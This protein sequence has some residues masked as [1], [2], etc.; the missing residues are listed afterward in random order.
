LR[1]PFINLA[2]QYES[3]KTELDEAVGRVLASGM[4]V[5]GEEVERFEEEFARY[6]GASHAVACSSGTSAIKLALLGA[7]IADGDEVITAANSFIATAGAIVHAGARPVFVDVDPATCNMDPGLVERAITPRTRAIVG[8]HLYG[9]PMDMDPVMEIAEAKG[10]VL[11]ED[12]A[13]AHGARYKGAHVGSIGHAGCF[14]FYPTKNLGACGEAGAVVTHSSEM[15]YKLRLLRDHGSESKYVHC[16][17]GYND[18]MDA[19][20]AAALRVKLRH[21]DEWV[22]SRRSLAREYGALLEGL[23]VETPVEMS[24]GKAV[25]HLYVVRCDARDELAEFLKE[26]GVG[27]GFHYP[28]P[29]HLQPALSGL[30]Y[31]SG[32][33]PVAERLASRVLSLPMYPE[34]KREDVSYV[35]ETVARALEAVIHEPTP[36]GGSGVPA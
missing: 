21:L 22:D 30:G 2:A 17:V 23:P 15:A 1:V 14:S 4:Y 29:L 19:V 27:I 13:Q 11:I 36:G 32:Q 26:R 5:Q 8:V 25:Y 7:G 31:Q 6:T 16:M 12:S 24:Y 10:L 34:L 28:V 9:H 33:M 20:Q 35:C 18:R 3:I